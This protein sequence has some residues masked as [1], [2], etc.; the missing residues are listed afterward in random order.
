MNDFG[1]KFM[2]S[3]EVKLTENPNNAIVLTP[4]ANF[5][6]VDEATTHIKELEIT[7][8]WKKPEENTPYHVHNIL[9]LFNGWAKFS[10]ITSETERDY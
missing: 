4:K 9:S 5:H 7:K 3:E 8:T 6:V 1:T 2:A 10:L